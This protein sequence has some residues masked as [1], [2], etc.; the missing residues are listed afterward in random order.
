[1]YHPKP[2]LQYYLGHNIVSTI[3]QAV[4]VKYKQ[5]KRPP[6]PTLNEIIKYSNQNPLFLTFHFHEL[7]FQNF[8]ENCCNYFLK[9]VCIIYTSRFIIFV[10]K[11]RLCALLRFPSK[12]HLLQLLFII[13]EE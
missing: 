2:S 1:M 9:T 6:P 3:L 12:S 5:Q 4:H 13:K 8:L 10:L 7:I 11:I